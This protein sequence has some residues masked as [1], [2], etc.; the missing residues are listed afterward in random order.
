MTYVA[1]TPLRCSDFFLIPSINCITLDFNFNWLFKNLL[2][3]DRTVEKVQYLFLVQYL[4]YTWVHIS[5]G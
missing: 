1:A 5:S 4:F 3:V 2:P